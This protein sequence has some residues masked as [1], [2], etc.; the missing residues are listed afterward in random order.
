MLTQADIDGDGRE[1]RGHFATATQ[2]GVSAYAAYI[3]RWKRIL[4]WLFGK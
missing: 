1:R 3:P 2:L 4:H